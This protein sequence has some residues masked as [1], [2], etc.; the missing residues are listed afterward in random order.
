MLTTFSSFDDRGLSGKLWSGFSPPTANGF[1]SMAA[2]N[3][4]FGFFDD[5]LRFDGTTLSQGYF[6]LA[7]GTGAVAQV[8][9]D[10]DR[11]TTANKLSTGL[12]ELQLSATAD[13]DEGVLA[14]GNGLD[15]PFTLAQKRDLA[16][17]CRVKM[18]VILA[19]DYCFFVG[20][21]ELGAQATTKIFDGGQDLD[22][23]YD[24]LGFQHLIAESTAIDGMYQVGGQTPVDGAV[25]TGLDT[26]HTLVAD[27][28]VK[29]GFRYR[30]STNTIHWYVN[31]AEDKGSRLNLA[32]IEAADSGT[33]PD[34]NFMTPMAIIGTDQ[35]TPMLATFDWWACA[36]AL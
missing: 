31:G 36:Q 35:A 15:A 3:P 4:A 26:L 22:N 12:G 25:N 5:F 33:F 29:L 23:T 21:G 1:E 17:E 13:N 24:L 10:Y 30:A 20:L 32:T 9:S 16:F 28:Y 7:T 19:A 27:A 11:S 6:T 8:A 14:F 18:S 34:D 2:G